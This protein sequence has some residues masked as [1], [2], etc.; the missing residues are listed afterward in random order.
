M[1]VS[2]QTIVR[3]VLTDALAV[4]APGEPIPPADALT[5]LE[6][7]NGVLDDWS[8]ERQSS[9]AGVLSAFTTTPALQP[10]TIGPTGTWVL[11][12]R[13]VKIDGLALALTAGFY[14]PI[15]V[16]DDPAWWLAQQANGLVAGVT[17]GA[18]YAP[19]VP[20]GAL[21]FLS[22]PSAAYDVLLLTRWVMGAAASLTASLILPP[23]YQSALELTTA[24]A[25]VDAFH[26]TLTEKQIQRAGKARAR[27]FGNNL[28]IPTLSAAG[29]GLPGM[30]GRRFDA[31]TGTW[32]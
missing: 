23:G 2:L 16:S 26:A 21:S 15:P 27:I 1:A 20:N 6:A 25:V 22:I 19:S 31:R 13:P 17:S 9:V 18:Y 11:P 14:T 29:L 30:G 8:A 12:V 28:V 10:H 24:E 5:V 3:H 7:V 4:Y 32:Y